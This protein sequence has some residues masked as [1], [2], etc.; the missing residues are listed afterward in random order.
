[1]FH[2]LQMIIH[3]IFSFFQSI[4]RPNRGNVKT[5]FL[6]GGSMLWFHV[7]TY[8]FWMIWSLGPG[9]TASSAS[10]YRHEKPIFE[11]V[12]ELRHF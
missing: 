4:F 10:I 12:Y 8:A 3:S 9:H 7:S 6:A 5:Y 11:H 2:K 1:M